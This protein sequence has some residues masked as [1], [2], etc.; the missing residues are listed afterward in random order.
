MSNVLRF[1][2]TAKTAAPVLGKD[3]WCSQLTLPDGRKIAGGPAREARIKAA[4]GMSAV[5]SD[6]FER[7][8]AL[9]S[10]RKIG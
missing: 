10:S 2:R 6:V 3:P 9:A 1:K 7:A 8:T 5:L 4:G